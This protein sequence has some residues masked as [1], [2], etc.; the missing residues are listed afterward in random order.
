MCKS[1]QPH[2]TI[3]RMFVVWQLV[4]SSSTGRREAIVQEYECI[5][6]L[7]TMR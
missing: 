7:R 6:K 3:L 5:R 4:S 2:T 1:F